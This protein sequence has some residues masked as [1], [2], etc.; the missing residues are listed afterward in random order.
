MNSTDSQKHGPEF[1]IVVQSM[2][3]SG[4]NMQQHTTK[5]NSQYELK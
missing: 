4:K 5:N 3:K 2:M 1:E